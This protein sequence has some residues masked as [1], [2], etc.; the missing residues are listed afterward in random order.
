MD[1]L[2]KEQA[3][4]IYRTVRMLRDRLCQKF[5][6]RARS[7]GAAGERFDIT[8][9]QGNVIMAI[10]ERNEVS[11]KEL[12]DILHVSPPSASG[13]VDRLMEMGLLVREQSAMDRR[14]VRIRLSADGRYHFEEMEA[15]ILECITEL[16]AK[17]GP[18]YSAQWCGV[19]DRIGEI[20]QL[21][22]AP[23]SLQG[24]EK[25]AVG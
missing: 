6:M 13:M 2:A 12:A 21:E 5:E 8:F 1:Q 23:E 19:Y 16:L 4:S 10:A 3:R 22:K 7:R 14:E 11:L 18:T 17:L 25:D 9:A 20:I 15:Q 24:L